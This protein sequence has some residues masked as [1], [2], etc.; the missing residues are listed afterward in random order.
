MLNAGS[1]GAIKTMVVDLRPLPPEG[2][3]GP[4][5]DFAAV[6]D[7]GR[8]CLPSHGCSDAGAPRPSAVRWNAA[9]SI[10]YAWTITVPVSAIVAALTWWAS[11]LSMSSSGHELQP[12]NAGDNQSDAGKAK[13]G[14]WLPKRIMPSAAVPTAPMP[15]QTA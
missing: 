14:G 6:G 8:D 5:S 9:S 7:I 1:E 13:R 15:V 10:V 12:D 2:C 3:I 11:M 4:F